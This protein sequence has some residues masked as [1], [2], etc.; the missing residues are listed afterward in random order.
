MTDNNDQ[1]KALARL[2][3]DKARQLLPNDPIGL[4]TRM[5]EEQH[6]IWS[7]AADILHT[8][9]PTTTGNV[10]SE[11]GGV[12]QQAGSCSVCTNCGSTTGCG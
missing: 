4:C 12:L 6:R 1:A 9:K 3:A 5:A 8:S 11:C 7:M 10:C 2:Y